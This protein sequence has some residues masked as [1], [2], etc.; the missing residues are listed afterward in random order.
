MVFDKQWFINWQRPLLWL[1]N[2]SYGRDVLGLHTKGSDVG[3]NKI[4]GILPNAI[5]WKEDNQ[6]FAEFRTHD[7]FSKR[8]FYEYSLIWRAIH[9][10]DTL[11]ANNFNPKFNLGFDTLTKYP[12]PNPET[13]TVDGQTD[14]SIVS[15]SFAVLR[16]GAATGS[17]DIS[18]TSEFSLYAS[19]TLNEFKFLYRFHC[20]FD[21]GILGNDIV[22]PSSTLSL[23]GTVTVANGLGGTPS[24]NI[25]SSAP[26]SNT[27]IA[28]GDHGNL[29]TTD[30]GSILWSNL[31]TGAYNDFNLNSSGI[32]NIIG[33]GISKF[34]AR[35]SFDR[36]NTFDG[37]WSSGASC[38]CV[39]FC[40]DQTGTSNDP[41]LVVNYTPSIDIVV[42]Q[43]STS[44]GRRY[45]VVGY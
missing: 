17:T 10:W 40:A 11:F 37:T 38:V 34:G 27:A 15:E 44:I 32:A 26:A 21:T 1:A 42:P 36:L 24:A 19:T 25:V 45:K 30:F 35:T 7:K 9:N 22:I 8:L 3:R 2:T 5:I 4:I 43:G 28:T 23:Y 41:K 39:V 14:R 13:T 29:G 12:D 6:H 18:A 16:A 31:V 33:G 20:L